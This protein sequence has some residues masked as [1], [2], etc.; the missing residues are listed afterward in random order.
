MYRIC[1]LAVVLVLCAT[2]TAHALSIVVGT[3]L[4]QPN[5]PNQVFPIYVQAAGGE[6]VAGLELH[7]QL[8]DGGALMG[9]SDITPIVGIDALSP[10]MLFASNGQVSVENSAPPAYAEALIITNFG[11]ITLQPGSNLLFNLTLDSVGAPDLFG[12][13]PI[14]LTGTAGGDTSF[15]DVPVDITNGAFAVVP[16][17]TSFAM[18]LCTT[19][20]LGAIFL[21]RRSNK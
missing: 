16:E 4:Y 5:T 15:F 11:T 17:P 21:L 13:L 3:Y 19:I 8:G 7:V 1:G 12:L 10:G 18:G 20:A 6:E 14:L 2:S 9:G